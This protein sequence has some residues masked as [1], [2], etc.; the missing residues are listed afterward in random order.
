MNYINNYMINNVEKA[1]P[2]LI[3]AFSYVYGEK[4]RDFIEERINSTKVCVCHGE[5]DSVELYRMLYHVEKSDMV[6]KEEL[7]KSIK[8]MIKLR[9]MYDKYDKYVLEQLKIMFPNLK[10]TDFPMVFIN[11]F[12]SFE[13][14]FGKNERENA[15][16]KKERITYFKELG[17]NLGDDYEA[18]ETNESAKKLVPSK[19]QKAEFKK[20]YNKLLA[21]KDKLEEYF[22]NNH[23]ELEEIL[24]KYRYD[25]K[26]IEYKDVNRNVSYC[27]PNTINGEVYPLC[28][29]NILNLMLDC[30]SVFVH[31]FSHALGLSGKNKCALYCRGKYKMINEALEEASIKAV[32]DYMLEK[33]YYVIH[34]NPTRDND[35]VYNPITPIGEAF[36][37]KFKDSM[38]IIRFGSEEELYKI[39]DPDTLEDLD[40]ICNTIISEPENTMFVKMLQSAAIK[41]INEYKPNMKR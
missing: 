24:I 12:N 23:K 36:L 11:A 27:M 21:T 16:I 39:I 1:K 19:L 41:K 3:E 22:S 8:V 4:R 37:E 29:F 33:G 13:K 25:K 20:L 7:I 14:R 32:Y 17:L 9:R 15:R 2:Y 35:S 18:Y 6:N 10:R 40:A 28:M 5:I 38:D 34:K 31:E 26:E 30:E